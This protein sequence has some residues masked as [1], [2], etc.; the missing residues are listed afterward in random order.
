MRTSV[1]LR[2]YGPTLDPEDVTRTLGTH[3]TELHKAG[4]ERSGANGRVYSPF[5]G[6]LWSLESGLRETAPLSEHVDN[7]LDRID[8]ARLRELVTD[9]TRVDLFVGVFADEEPCN[10]QIKP[11]TC[12]RIGALGIPLDISIYP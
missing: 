4:D 3:A 12:E 8:S 5:R 1:A 7:I 11:E 9:G 6:G 2:V 10:V